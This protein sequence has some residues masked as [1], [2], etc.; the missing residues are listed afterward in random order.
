MS[1]LYVLIGIVIGVFLASHSPEIADQIRH[2]S[3][4]VIEAIQGIIRK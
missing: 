4:E 1:W 2:Y 3:L